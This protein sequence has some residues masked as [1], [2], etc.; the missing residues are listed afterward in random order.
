MVSVALPDQD[1][2]SSARFVL[3]TRP[4]G[5]LLSHATDVGAGVVVGVD[6]MAPDRWCSVAADAQD[7]VAAPLLQALVGERALRAL[8]ASTVDRPAT[9]P[10]SMVVE[11]G[12]A[13]PWLR[14]AVVDALDRW[15]QLPLVQSLV[16]AERG[17]S[18]GRAAQT[19]PRRSMAREVVVGEALYLARQAAGGL[20][21]YLGGLG[22]RPRTVPAG[23]MGALRSLAAGYIDL[24]GEVEESSDHQLTAVLDAWQLVTKRVS[25][26]EDDEGGE[27]AE[28]PIRARAF[29]RRRKQSR[30]ASLIDP[31]QVR[32][33]VFALST[34]PA[35]AE[36]TMADTQVGS[37]PAVLVRVP[38]YRRALEQPVVQRLLVRLVDARSADPQGQ[39]VLTVSPTPSRRRGRSSNVYFEGVVPLRGSSAETLRADVFDALSDVPPAMADSDRTLHEVRRATVFLSEWRRLLAEAQ[40]SA[41][42]AAPARGLRELAER[43][44]ADG[45]SDQP[46]F[47][48]GPSPI[49]LGRLADA[50]DRELVSAA[51]LLGDEGH[52]GLLATASG[53]GA[54]LAAEVAAAFA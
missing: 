22:A 42:G 21:G 8:R 7:D 29:V 25:I 45:A 32:A 6:L 27:D 48:A 26:R 31:R 19:L 47:A 4:P 15:L 37:S 51:R 33:R 44:A 52:E 28:D 49:D 50:D 13:R 41:A 23:L 2:E 39:S 46:L 30:S 3:T 40:I 18:R 5:G 17:V 54:L 10:R 36:V 14:V 24:L 38:A 1:C 43:L 16:D 11:P 20:I 34:D 53:T 12:A 9:A 35:S